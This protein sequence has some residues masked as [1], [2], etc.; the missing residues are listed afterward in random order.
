MFETVFFQMFEKPPVN[1]YELYRN[2]YVR[3]VD[4]DEYSDNEIQL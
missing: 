2:I 1:L 3:W 4:G